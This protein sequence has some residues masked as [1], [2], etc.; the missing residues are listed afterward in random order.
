M[1]T[2]TIN[3]ISLDPISQT[4]ALS[5]ASLIANDAKDSNYLLIQTK[6]PLDTDQKNELA[7]L[8]VKLLEYVPDATYIAN[9]APTD[10]SKIR[11]LPYVA[12]AN[13]YLHGFKLAPALLTAAGDL[14]TANLMA[15]T[16]T[17]PSAAW[18]QPRLVDVV[19]QN[20]VQPDSVLDKVAGAAHLDPKTLKAGTQKFRI[21]VQQRY[22]KDLAAIDEVRHVEDVVPLK[23]HNNFARKILAV[24]GN[25]GGPS[26]FLGDGQLVAVGDTGFDVGSTSNVHPAFAGR[27]QKL[28]ALGRPG[29]ASDPDGHGTHVAGSVLGDGNSAAMG[30]AIQGTAPKAKLV[31][32]SLLDAGGGLGGI[33]ADLHDLFEDPYT[34]DG[35]RVHTN[36]WGST[37][38]DGSYDANARELDDFVW[39][40][41]D[42]V[43]C[44]A[45][46]NSGRDGSRTGHIDPGSVS[47]PSTAKNCITVGATE[48]NRPTIDIHYD[49]F[50]F[51]AS[52]F[53]SDLV[54]DN[55]EGMAAFSGRGPTTDRRIKP[56]VVAPGTAIL[57]TL[58]RSVVSPSTDWGVSSDPAFF[59]DGGTSMSTPL[60]AGCTALVR[61]FLLR[62]HGNSTPS[63]ALVKALLINGA[64]PIAG[65]YTPS[66]V[67]NIPGI[68]EG[69][70]RVNIL[71][72]VGP[73]PA[74]VTV[75]FKDEATLLDTNQQE[76]TTV[77]IPAGAKQ[78][79][80]TLVWTDPAGETLQ[81]DLDLIVKTADGQER[82]GNVPSSSTDFDRTNNVEQVVWPN[83]AAGNATITVKAFRVTSVPAQP[84]ALVT[85]VS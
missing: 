27:V 14:T 37:V 34:V 46:G 85:R 71:A 13:T 49:I 20:G 15:A 72:T 52:P 17:P 35:A 58:S 3:G 32:Q 16:T 11:A 69:F 67:G 41:R 51:P 83:P 48:N 2:I 29:D 80:V 65:Q 81:N 77:A 4:R 53:A 54:A 82:H 42:L 22:L 8:G 21:S 79:K 1:A 26:R 24:M 74:G 63:A 36:S 10:L 25:P 62:D 33:P 6:Q 60:I 38:G 47:A 55:P 78:L 76:S 66:E 28:Y 45:A 59:F 56:D 70:G 39:N 64:H 18:R 31:L 5:A 68:S 19:L 12:W 50:G 57:S 73:F 9:Y 40:H 84:Y 75:D 30:G 44:F 43:V 23:L 7:G 61:E